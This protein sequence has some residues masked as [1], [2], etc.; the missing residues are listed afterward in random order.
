MRNIIIFLLLALII[1][2]SPLSGENKEETSKIPFTYILPGIE[3]IKHKD[4][5]KGVILLTSFSGC[6]TGAIINNNRGNDYYEKYLNSVIVEEI[7]EMRRKTEDSFRKRNYFLVG[8]F[9]V[10]I[11]HLI[12]LQFFNNKTKG[13][14]GEIR[15]NG[16]SF[17]LYYTF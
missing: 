1:F 2:S 8:A 12:D 7:V 4:Y 3:Q 11:I 17:G 9:S 15:K 5:L 10:W 14:K 6:I 16:F 13:V